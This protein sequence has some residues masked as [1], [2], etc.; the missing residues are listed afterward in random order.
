MLRALLSVCLRHH[1]ALVVV[2]L[3]CTILGFASIRDV[4]VDAFPEFAPPRVE[5][6]TEAPGLSTLEVESLVTRPIEDAL[7]GVPGAI[8]LRSNSVLGMSSVVVLFAPGSDLLG[9]RQLVQERL[10]LA[11]PQ[12]PLLARAPVLRP[13]TSSTSRILKIGMRSDAMSITELGQLARWTVRPRLMAIP[14][15][16]NVAI[17][18]ERRPQ[19]QVLVDPDRLRANGVALADIVRASGEAVSPISGGFV[20]GDNQ[21]FAVAEVAEIDSA[22]ALA[23]QPLSLRIGTPLSL[24]QVSEVVESHAP[25]IGDAVI[26]G[27]PGLLLIVEKQPSGNTLEIT[28]Q[29]DAA[30]LELAPALPGVETDASIFRTARFIERA[31]SNLELAL[32]LGCA[33]VIVVLLVFLFDWRSALISAL[34][35]PTSLLTSVVILDRLGATLDTMVLAGLAIALGEVVDDA[36]IDVE[37]IHRRLLENHRSATPR[38]S[39][40]VVLEASLEVRSAVVYASVIVILVFV[41]VALLGGLAGAF[42]RPLAIAYVLAIG[43]SLLVALTLTPALALLLLPAGIARARAA[44]LPRA[45]ARAYAPLLRRLLGSPRLIAGGTGLLMALGVV[46]FLQLGTSFL[47]DFRE[48][49]FLMHWIAK[50]GASVA[51]VR[52][53]TERV[54]VELLA[55]P[56]VRNSGA[57]IGRAEVA[58]EIVGPNFGE[59]WVSVADDADHE[60]TVTAIEQTLAR[61]PGLYRDVQTYL[62]ESVD[63]VLTGGHSELVVRVFGPDLGVLEQRADVIADGLRAIPGTHEVAIELQTPVPQISIRAKPA[64]AE[65]FG[66]SNAEL[67]RQVNILVQGQSVGEVVRQ[68]RPL[69]VVVWGM[70]ELRN[71]VTSLRE[72][73][74]EGPA[75]VELRL[76]DVADVTI[77]PA[78]GS[79]RHE[80]GSRRLDISCGVEGRALGDVA[81]DIDALLATLEFPPAHHAELLGEHQASEAASRELGWG[82]AF[83]IV[84]ILLVLYIDFR[85][86]RATLLVG[87]GLPFALFGAVASVWIGSGTL[88]LGALVGFVTLIGVAARNGIMLVSHYRHLELVAGLPF[89]EALVIRGTLERLSPILMTALST[90]LALLPL[91]LWGDRPG[92][93]IEHPMALAILGGLVS[94]TVLN[95]VVMPV[96]YLRWAASATRAPDDLEPEAPAD[97]QA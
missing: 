29:I 47:P 24:G 20:D 65:V 71:D 39:A 32:G 28:R 50:P 33:L 63:E 10:A 40:R 17:W 42:F 75:G 58:D 26:D 91:A 14:G 18:G 11:I 49:D 41:P 80:G 51:G 22:A 97:A 55:I 64:A 3:I 90:G 5:I 60:A 93:E 94:S 67:R 70:P 96:A 78:P 31:V 23:R 45:L 87:L 8:G 34:A 89:G 77:E 66:L 15:V 81:E 38:S 35:I 9:A 56:G 4:R 79:I 48:Q 27:G 72:L 54:S 73:R 36:I 84:G 25:L 37:N 46:G 7:A 76:G 16:A 21:R 88:S 68:Q 12:L 6:Q 74:L 62:R 44:S 53:T 19:L 52:R 1:S 13:P 69:G 30:L 59:I 83:T 2:A 92:H 85:D 61:Y 82:V 57:H 86:V 43:S 95:L